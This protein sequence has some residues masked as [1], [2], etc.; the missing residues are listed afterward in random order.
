MSG[1]RIGT[2]RSR[3]ECITN[4][5]AQLLGTSHVTYFS[6]QLY[7]TGSYITT[8]QFIDLWTWFHQ[9]IL[10]IFTILILKKCC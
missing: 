6:A 7:G 8:L 3:A 1:F 2:F 10:Y 5:Y 4:S 9:L